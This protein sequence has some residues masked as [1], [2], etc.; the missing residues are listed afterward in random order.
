MPTVVA[1]TTLY[2]KIA[3]TWKLNEFKFFI[4]GN[5]IS[6]DLSGSVMPAGTLNKLEFNRANGSEKMNGKINQL[7]VYP[8]ALSDSELTT[9]TTL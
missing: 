3:V 7:Q 4:N 5:K 1:D 2:S 9:L 8:S 6:E